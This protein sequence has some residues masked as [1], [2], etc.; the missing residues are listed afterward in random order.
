MITRAGREL[1]GLDDEPAKASEE[2]ARLG[3]Q[4]ANFVSA[5]ESPR[6]G[7]KQALVVEMLSTKAGTTLENLIEVTG[8][9]SHTTRAALTGLRKRGLRG[10]E[11]SSSGQA[12]SLSHRGVRSR[13]SGLSPNGRADQAPS[14]DFHVG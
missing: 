10:A 6:V 7:S 14:A 2:K 1:I 5:V 3:T 8:W 9:L 13:Q 12:L 4:G 11:G